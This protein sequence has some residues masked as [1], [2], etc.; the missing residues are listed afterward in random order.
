MCGSVGDIVQAH[1]IENNEQIPRGWPGSEGQCICLLLRIYI[2]PSLE[3]WSEKW[4]CLL[5]T[6]A[7]LCDL[8]REEQILAG[9]IGIKKM[10]Y[11]LPCIFQ[12]DD[13]EPQFGWMSALV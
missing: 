13:I 12:L 2:L 9:V 11:N 5:N 6:E 1:H 7:F 4:W 8:L 10:G 3:S